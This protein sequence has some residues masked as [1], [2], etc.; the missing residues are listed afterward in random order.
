MVSSSKPKPSARSRSTRGRKPKT[1]GSTSIVE[2]LPKA[3][4]EIADDADTLEFLRAI[5]K[6]KRTSG[7]NF[8]SWSEV[9]VIVRQLGYS[10]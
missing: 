9:L 10:K 5:D 3:P 1:N 8:P 4:N 6:F 2:Q 7:R